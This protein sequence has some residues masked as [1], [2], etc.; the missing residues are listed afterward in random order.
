[1]CLQILQ[2]HTIYNLKIGLL[3]HNS[4]HDS[5]IK[6]QCLPGIAPVPLGGR[7]EHGIGKMTNYMNAKKKK[8]SKC[9]CCND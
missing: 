2:F 4:T 7:L 8:K 3:I 1:M 5:T 9:P 6:I